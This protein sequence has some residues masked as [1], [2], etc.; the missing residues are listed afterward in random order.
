MLENYGHLLFLGLVVSKPDLV[1]FLEKKRVLW[2]VKRKETIASYPAVSLDDTEKLLPKIFTESSF[3]RVSVDRYKPSD[4]ENGHLVMDW[5]RDGE[6][7]GHQRCLGTLFPE[8]NYECNKYREVFGQ[9]ANLITHKS[10]HLG[11]N[12]YKYNECG[13]IVNQS[14]NVGDQE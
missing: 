9:S 2:D 6:N 4:V 5:N 12:P 11:E 10:M 1:I 3:Q 13:K 7:E 14:F 8:N